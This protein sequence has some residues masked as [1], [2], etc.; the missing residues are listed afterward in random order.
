MNIRFAASIVL[1]ASF[2]IATAQTKKPVTKP[3]VKPKPTT[4][5]NP[6]KNLK[7][8]T[9]Y[10]LGVSIGHSLQSQNLSE[11]NTQFLLKGINEV[12]QH[13]KISLTEEEAGNIINNFIQKENLKKSEANKVAGKKFLEANGKRQGVTTL[14]DGLQYE[15]LKAGTDTTRPKL[16]DKV[17]C[18]YHG[19]LIDGTVF[20]SSVD[21]GEPATF[22][23][24]GVIKGWQE[25]LP[26]MTVGSK[27]KLF[28]PS[29][30]AYGDNPA[31]PKIGPGSTLVFEVELLSIEK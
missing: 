1:C 5:V 31:G 22:P 9:S 14:P 16:T 21:R 6:L 15:V 18:H 4:P 25:A 11:I 2:G 24:N 20:D 13:K 28:I 3:S 10:A 23:V 27:W 19:T 7:D 8:S 17:K 12:L 26:M 29:S 30:L